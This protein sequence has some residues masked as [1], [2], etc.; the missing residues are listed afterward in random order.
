MSKRKRRSRSR[1]S[2]IASLAAEAQGIIRSERKA[3]RKFLSKALGVTEETALKVQR[4]LERTGFMSKPK[5]QRGFWTLNGNPPVLLHTAPRRSKAVP[6]A[7]EAEPQKPEKAQPSSLGRDKVSEDA[8]RL[9][10]FRSNLDDD[11]SGVA[12]PATDLL[13]RCVA[14]L[15]RYASLLETLEC[16]VK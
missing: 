13:E 8:Q 7:A 6:A 14:H 16:D 4:H 12:V 15:E 10:A 3:G 11:L 5:S 1:V 2:K 9:L